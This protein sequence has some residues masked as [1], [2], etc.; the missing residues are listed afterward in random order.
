M[1]AQLT[2]TLF[3][4]T[5]MITERRKLPSNERIRLEQRAELNRRLDADER[6][7]ITG[8]VAPE[9]IAATRAKP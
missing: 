1:R 6:D 2:S 8:R 3:S 9:V 5:A 7:G 4:D